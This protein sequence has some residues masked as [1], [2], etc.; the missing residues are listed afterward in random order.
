MIRRWLIAAGLLTTLASPA[1]AAT[2]ATSGVFVPAMGDLHC[3]ISNVSVTTYVA[4][5]TLLDENGNTVKAAG[6]ALPPGKSVSISDSNSSAYYG[7]CQFD[8]SGP[9]GAFRAASNLYAISN[10][11][12]VVIPAR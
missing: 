10:G 7:R 3:N 8:V 4:N 11:I 1:A 6:F 12:P 5:V 9:K 2:L